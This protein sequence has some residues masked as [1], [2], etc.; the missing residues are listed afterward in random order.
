MTSPGGTWEKIGTWLAAVR[1]LSAGVASSARGFAAAGD[2]PAASDSALVPPARTSS[3]QRP[4]ACQHC[5]ASA[6][7]TKRQASTRGLAGMGVVPLGLTKHRASAHGL[8]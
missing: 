7:C 8:A 5:A 1:P 4:D 3:S 2:A 6:A